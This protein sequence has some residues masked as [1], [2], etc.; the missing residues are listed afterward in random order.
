MLT[1][2]RKALIA[3]RLN[4]DGEVIAKALAAEL[5]LSEDT[6]RRDLRDM[7]AEGL[8]RRVHGGALPVAPD[9]PDFATRQTVATAE[10]DAI[11]RRASELVRPGT[12]VFL[13]GGTTTAALAR[14]LP[15]HF[16]FTVVTHSP[17]IAC[18]LERHPTADVV[19]IGGRL[20]KH[21]M[22]AV[23]AMALEAIRDIRADIYFLGVTAAHPVEGLTTGDMEEARTKRAIAAA[24]AETWVMLT[25]E[26]LGAVSP[27]KVMPMEDATGMLVPSGLDPDRL[28]AFQTLDL[29][30][31][32]APQS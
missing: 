15:R 27:W 11:A 30:V 21:S 9:L 22:V 14:A 17:T 4:R 31:I 3:E 2:Q 29:D 24:A 16:A 6:I 26:K 1:S 19:M 25:R 20:Y 7:A 23:G 28:R 13:D 5:A 8:L 32:E 18:E 10:K 12:V